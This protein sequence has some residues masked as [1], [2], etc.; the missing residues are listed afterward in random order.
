[1]LEKNFL[2][3]I[4]L[5]FTISITNIFMVKMSNWILEFLFKHFSLLNNPLLP[6]PPSPQNFL[7]ASKDENA[8]LKA[9]DFGLSD[10]VKPGL[11]SEVPTW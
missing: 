7:Y 2:L 3:E 11:P 10:F 9:I 5:V 8:E 1:M 6:T 4:I